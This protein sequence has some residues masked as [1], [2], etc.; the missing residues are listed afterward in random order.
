VTAI[1]VEFFG[2][3]ADGLQISVQ[4]IEGTVY[5]PMFQYR[6][7]PSPPDDR[8]PAAP[9]RVAC[10]RRSAPRPGETH[11]RYCYLPEASL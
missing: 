11:W 5:P 7:V 2:G 3:R 4:A 6:E 9:P 10:Y 1:N 8:H